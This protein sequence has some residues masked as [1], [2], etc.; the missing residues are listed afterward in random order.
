MNLYRIPL[1]VFLIGAMASFLLWNTFNNMHESDEVHAFDHEADHIGEQIAHRLNVYT[2]VLQGARGLFEASQAV[3]REE[4]KAFVAGWNLQ[5]TYPGIQALGYSMVVEPE[6]LAAHIEQ[7]RSEGFPDY[8]VYPETVGDFYLPIVYIEP[9]EGNNLQAFGY[10][11]LSESTRQTALDLARDTGEITMTGKVTLAQEAGESPQAG[12]LLF[13]PIYQ[14]EAPVETVEERQEAIM[15]YVFFAFRMNDLMDGIFQTEETT[16]VDFAI[17]DG[18]TASMEGEMYASNGNFSSYKTA[19]VRQRVETTIQL[20]EHEWTLIA[21]TSSAFRLSPSQE[22]FAPLALITGLI[23]SF[24]FSL[25]LYNYNTI[26]LHAR[27]LAAKM[28]MHLRDEKDALA[29]STAKTTAILKSIGDGVVATDTAGKILFINRAARKMLGLSFSEDLTGKKLM[30]ITHM[31]DN[32]G[33]LLPSSKR[34]L[35]QILKG[36]ASAITSNTCSYLRKGRA[37]I[38]VALTTTPIFLQKK[39]IGAIEIFRDTTREKEVDRVKTEFVSFASHQL[40]TPLTSI[41]WYAELLLKGAVGKLTKQQKQYL[42]EIHKGDER[43]V[44]LVESLLNVSRLEL[45]TLEMDKKKLDPAQ[46]M[47][48]VLNEVLPQIKE[49][50]VRVGTHF[51]PMPKLNTDAN[52]LHMIFQNLVA[53]AVAYSKNKGSIKITLKHSKKDRAYLITVQDEGC[54]IPATEQDKIFSKLFRAKNVLEK[55]PSGIG[56]G[57]YIVKMAVEKLKG[58]VWFKTE[59][60]KG[61]T[62]FVSLPSA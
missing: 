42:K 1:I 12:F 57:L 60:S 44:H 61:T 14:N 37:P 35:S 34:P 4:W 47:K 6:N 15:G 13:L 21:M 32:A 58:K 20:Y 41:K 18:P 55:S 51:G 17:Y 2:H 50:K 24:L 43:M 39:L 16:G 23:L 28:T 22:I 7:V 49:K 26:Q 11:Q 27:D 48:S 10:N 33:K 30:D 54:G 8:T 40:R 5:E 29:E 46:L 31:C 38:P 36:R 53:N 19:N 3:E 52:L 9:F 62:F 59:E 45:G 56:L 25:L